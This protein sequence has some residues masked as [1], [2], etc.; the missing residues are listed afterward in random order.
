MTPVEVTIPLK[1]VS[2]A[3][4]RE[5]WAVRANRARIH[6]FA[7]MVVP[8][9]RLPCVVTITRI[10]PTPLDTDNLAIS[11]KNVRDG[12]ADRLGANDN[13]PLIEWQYAQEK[14]KRGEYGVRIRIEPA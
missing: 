14:C 2:T 3:N 10:G 13:S 1:L 4:Q 9:H 5:H 8:L 6:R 11:A 12:I 7:C